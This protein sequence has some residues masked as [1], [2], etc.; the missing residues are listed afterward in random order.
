MRPTRVREGLAART[1]SL[2]VC[3]ARLAL[4]VD[5]AASLWEMW[6][7]RAGRGMLEGVGLSAKC[8]VMFWLFGRF[9]GVPLMVPV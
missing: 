2:F 5:V 3:F 4:S 1:S 7:S 6:C 8:V 9:L